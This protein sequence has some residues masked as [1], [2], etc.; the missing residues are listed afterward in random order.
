MAITDSNIFQNP[1]IARYLDYAPDIN[2]KDV[3]F[4]GNVNIPFEG[5]TEPVTNISEIAPTGSTKNVL[6]QGIANAALRNQFDF[7][8]PFSTVVRGSGQPYLRDPRKTYD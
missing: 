4:A 3:P 6:A 7:T 5:R 2:I 8:Q 1:A